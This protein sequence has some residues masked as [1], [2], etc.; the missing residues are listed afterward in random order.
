VTGN[1]NGTASANGA[2]PATALDRPAASTVRD[3]P[4]VPRGAWWTLCAVCP[5]GEAAHVTTTLTMRD[6]R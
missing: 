4:F 3:H 5:F 2:A 6:K 1:N